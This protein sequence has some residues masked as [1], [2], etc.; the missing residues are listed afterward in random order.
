[1][2]QGGEIDASD[3]ATNHANLN[4]NGEAPTRKRERPL[5]PSRQIRET[6]LLAE[7]GEAHHSGR[8]VALLG[9]NQLRGA[10]VGAVRVLVIG[11]VAINQ[12]DD[13]GV[14][15]ERARFTQVRELGTMV[16]A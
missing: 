1:M 13:V 9:E 10:G 2:T 16:G 6:R 3:G 8:A 11:I 4:T 5:S 7:E 15:L 12:D 14:L